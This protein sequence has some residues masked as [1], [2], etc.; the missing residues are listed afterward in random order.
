MFWILPLSGPKSCWPLALTLARWTWPI[1][2]AMKIRPPRRSGCASR[3]DLRHLRHQEPST[4]AV[5]GMI[6]RDDVYVVFSN[7]LSFY[8]FLSI[9]LYVWPINC[10]ELPERFSSR[11]RR[12]KAEVAW[13]TFMACSW[14][15]IRSAHSSRRSAAFWAAS[16]VWTLC[17]MNFNKWVCLKNVY[18]I[19]YPMVLLITIPFLNGYN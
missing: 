14:Q 4:L 17:A 6:A 2:T 12:C 13:R 16:I 19:V 10:V 3:R 8:H 9:Y 18:Q 7:Y 11:C 1:W 5:F 15:G